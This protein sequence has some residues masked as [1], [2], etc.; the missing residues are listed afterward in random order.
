MKNIAAVIGL[1][2]TFLVGPAKA[3]PD[4]NLRAQDAAEI[5]QLR[6]KLGRT[7]WIEKPN[8]KGV[9]LCPSSRERF[10][11]CVWISNTSFRLT[12]LDPGEAYLGLHA[13]K[14]YGVQTADGRSGFINTIMRS[15]FLGFDPVAKGKAD[16]EE[17]TRRD[18][19]LV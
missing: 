5:A 16:A 12:S 1:L 2:A 8:G 6:K 11:E 15:H 4:E 9:E 19:R 7:V 14:M 18:P 17:C 3:G 13:V 10:K